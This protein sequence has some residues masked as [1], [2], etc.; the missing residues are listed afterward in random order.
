MTATIEHT[1]ICGNCGKEWPAR[2]GKCPC[3]MRRVHIHN[4]AIVVDPGADL[5]ETLRRLTDRL[6]LEICS[7]AEGADLAGEESP[8]QWHLGRI[9]AAIGHLKRFRRE[10]QGLSKHAHDWNDNDYCSICGA[11]GRA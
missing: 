8:Y 4:K 7:S 10:V 3:N 5:L 1:D 9:D 2:F 11:D 6:E